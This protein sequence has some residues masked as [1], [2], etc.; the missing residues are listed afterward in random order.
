MGAWPPCCP[1]W[2]G[3]VGSVLIALILFP[4]HPIFH[5]PHFADGRDLGMGL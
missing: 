1:G 2:G 3:T 5:V 4:K